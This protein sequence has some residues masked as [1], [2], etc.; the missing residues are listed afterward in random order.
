MPISREQPSG[1]IAKGFVRQGHRSGGEGGNTLAGQVSG[2]LFQTGQITVGEV[3]AH[4]AVNVNI[5][6]AGDHGSALQVNGIFRNIFQHSAKAAV[7]GYLKAA[8]T[9]GMVAAVDS[10]VFIEH[11]VPHFLISGRLAAATD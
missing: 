1:R 11:R 3:S 8:H 6:Q 4:S 2:H 7:L 10:C 5:H 9:E